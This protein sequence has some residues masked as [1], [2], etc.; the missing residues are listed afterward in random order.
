MLQI[1]QTAETVFRRILDQPNVDAHAIRLVRGG[2]PGGD[3]RISVE[4]IDQPA[5]TDEPVEAEGLTVV[6]APD[7]ASELDEAVLDARE[8][9]GGGRPLSSP[10]VVAAHE[11]NASVRRV[12]RPTRPNRS[13]VSPPHDVAAVAAGPSAPGSFA[14]GRAEGR[15]GGPAHPGLGRRRV[16]TPTPPARGRTRSVRRHRGLSARRGSLGDRGAPAYARPGHAPPAGPG[17]RVVPRHRASM[18]ADGAA[19]SLW[20]GARARLNPSGRAA[21]R[22]EPSRIEP[23]RRPSRATGWRSERGGPPGCTGGTPTSRAEARCR[24]GYIDLTEPPVDRPIA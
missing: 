9:D 21:R 13:T 5:P 12:P 3:V 16:G 1:T 4:A 11:R 6:M 19:R 15:S 20:C 17:R 22:R 18:A 8:T 10:E 7:L 2:E 14:A 24:I 23:P